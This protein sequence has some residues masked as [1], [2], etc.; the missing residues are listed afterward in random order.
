MPF[1]I[2]PWV[3]ILVVTANNLIPHWKEYKR[4]N[5][6]SHSS[7]IVYLTCC[8]LLFAFHLSHGDASPT[9]P[10]NNDSPHPPHC[11]VPLRTSKQI[12]L[13][14]VVAEA[15][16]QCLTS[17]SHPQV[18]VTRLL[19]STLLSFSRFNLI[20]FRGHCKNVLNFEQL[21]HTF[22]FTAVLQPNFAILEHLNAE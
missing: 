3:S 16:A 17:S 22:T 20:N 10:W 6:T 14:S 2:P 5:L 19:S 1:P 4:N 13:I 15:T 8:V 12:P 11:S 18:D 7:W 9:A 21:G